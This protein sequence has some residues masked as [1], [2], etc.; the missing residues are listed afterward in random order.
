MKTMKH[1]F[2]FLF[3]ISFCLFFSWGYSLLTEKTESEHNVPSIEVMEI[4]ESGVFP[5][6]VRKI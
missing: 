1:I 6:S 5:D 3:I 2:G 4:S